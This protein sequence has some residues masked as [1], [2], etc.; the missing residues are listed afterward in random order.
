MLLADIERI[1]V[2]RGPGAVMWG[3]NA[4]N[5]VIHIITKNSK[6]TQGGMLAVQGGDQNRFGGALRYGGR[7]SDHVSYRGTMMGFRRQL[8][9]GSNRNDEWDARRSGF[10]V[11][12][13]PSRRDSLMAAGSF[14]RHDLR[15]SLSAAS[16]PSGADVMVRWKRI[17]TDR[18]DFALQAYY[19]R[20]RRNDSLISERRD[21]FDIDFQHR[22]GAGRIHDVLWGGEIRSIADGFSSTAAASVTP[23]TS[24][25]GLQ[26][27]FV[28]D[29]M[30]LVEDRFFVTAGTK[31]EHN[32]YT[33]AEV[34]PAVQLTWTPS[35]RT[36]VWTSISRSVR[37]PSRTDRGLNA[38][39]GETTAPGGL[40]VVMKLVASDSMRS[41][42][43]L[44]YEA[45]YRTQVT[46]RLSVDVAA[47]NHEYDR[48]RTTERQPTVLVSAPT[49]HLILP[50]Q[51]Q[52]QM[53]GSSVGGE[54]FATWDAAPR[55]TLF[56][57]YSYLHLV[58]HPYPGSRNVNTGL[59][60]GESPRHQGSV[61][62][63]IDLGRGWNWDTSVYAVGRLPAQ[64]VAGYLRVDARIAW[65]PSRSLEISANVENLMDR[66]H[67]EFFSPV[68][69]TIP[70]RSSF[71]RSV[72]IGMTWR[73]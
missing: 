5:G 67:L 1:E 33:G 26:T 17:L 48:L 38:Y 62:S 12:G 27:A 35:H 61:R 53:S 13:E 36:S 68:D 70:F 54:I 7:I 25:T 24:R 22:F 63:Q 39:L 19:D 9:P 37:L 15:P 46:D 43:Q 2:I 40:R 28:Q 42:T 60:A 31:V 14:Y 4:V 49:P 47:F 34:Q 3:A 59:Q 52:N 65:R 18:S 73:F 30:Q 56:P 71:G 50:L 64:S 20:T 29:Q 41:E 32:S 23:E 72:W 58:L 57:S 69:F 66:D 10:R 16:E 45:G 44:A 55:W 51:V 21:E 8:A 11:D 6:D